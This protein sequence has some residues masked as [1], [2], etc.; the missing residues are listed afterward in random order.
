MN[1]EIAGKLLAL[2]KQNGL[3]Q[4]ELAEKLGISR[5]SVSK[6]ERAEASP[7]TGNL[8]ALARIYNISLDLL[9]GIKVQDN[10]PR[11]D[12]SLKKESYSDRNP[13]KKTERVMYPENSSSEEIYPDVSGNCYADKPDTPDIRVEKSDNDLGKYLGEEETYESRNTASGAEAVYKSAFFRLQSDKKLYKKMMLFP[14][15]VFAAFAFVM[16]GALFELWH[17]MWMIFLTVPLYYTT[18]TA[19]H[20]Q[21][22]N[23]FCYPALVSIFYFFIGFVFELWHPGWLLFLT[24]PVYYWAVNLGKLSLKSMDKNI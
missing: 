16:S 13:E 21:N 14:Y 24:I 6:W 17:P 10:T 11:S 9:L 18:L 22:A 4:E 1:K 12:I 7:D 20:K 8:I 2:R 3:S 15:P 19:I 23:I 5:Q